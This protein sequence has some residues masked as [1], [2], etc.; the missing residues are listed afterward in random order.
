MYEPLESRKRITDKAREAWDHFTSS[1][2]HIPLCMCT[3]LCNLISSPLDYHY[4][5]ILNHH[6]S[7]NGLGAWTPQTLD[8]HPI[9]TKRIL[10]YYNKQTRWIHAPPDICILARNQLILKLLATFGSCTRFLVIADHHLFSITLH[11]SPS[12]P[13]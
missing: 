11:F 6:R 5:E 10:T 3:C 2:V 8:P 12:T 9:L 4:F 7:Y 1:T 13:W